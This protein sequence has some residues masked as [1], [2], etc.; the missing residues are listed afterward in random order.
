MPPTHVFSH[1]TAAELLGLRLPEGR[2]VGVLHVGALHPVRAPKSVGV[3][4]HELLA[5]TR[6]VTTTDGYRVTSPLDTWLSSASIL[7]VDDLI[8]MGDGLVCRNNPV[9]TLE[10]LH[11]A[12]AGA[13]GRPGAKRLRRALDEI[14]PRTDSARETML[15]LLLVRA[16]LPEAEVNGEIVDANGA[17][18]GF[19]DLLFREHRVLVEYDGGEHRTDERQFHRDVA[20]LDDVMEL[21]IRVIRVNKSLMSQAQL[22]IAKVTRALAGSV[23][24]RE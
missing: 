14:R 13:R 20:R 2:Q 24:S 7:R 3:R 12:V 4:G 17:F 16:G 9:A 11:H 8:V 15:R 6:T 23:P 22:L 5:R 21:G 10:Q 1:L 19:G 18:V